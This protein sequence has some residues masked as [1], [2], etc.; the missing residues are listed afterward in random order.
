MLKLSGAVDACKA[1]GDIWKRRR[2][3]Q[4]ED[5]EGR[6][7]HHE[8]EPDAGRTSLLYAEYISRPAQPVDRG[9]DGLGDIHKHHQLH[10]VVEDACVQRPGV[11][12]PAGKVGDVGFGLGKK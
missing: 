9:V 2:H 3:S 7:V 5:L 8:K 1:G 11:R 6:Q 4:Q 10:G 12:R